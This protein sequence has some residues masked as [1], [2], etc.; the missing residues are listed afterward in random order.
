MEIQEEADLVAETLWA[1]GVRG[2]FLAI[3]APVEVSVKDLHQFSVDLAE[4]WGEQD[5]RDA[6]E[7]L[8]GT[9]EGYSLLTP[10]TVPTTPGTISAIGAKKGVRVRALVYLAFPDTREEHKVIRFDVL[11]IKKGLLP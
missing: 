8:A 4:P 10:P 3:D 2:T 1:K 9:V 11:A 6:G 5:L 7:V